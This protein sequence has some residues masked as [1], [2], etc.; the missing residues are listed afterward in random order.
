MKEFRRSLMIGGLTAALVMGCRGFA[1]AEASDAEKHHSTAMNAT[2]LK[3]VE[4]GEK[5]GYKVLFLGNSITLHG[6]APK[7]GWTNHCGMA[8]STVSNDY[9]HLVV[10]GLERV[11]RQKVEAHVLNIAEFERNFKDYDLA[12]GLANEIAFEPDLVVLAIGENVPA[13]TKKEDAAEYGKAFGRLIHL[14][15][16]DRK[17]PP[18][19]L[20][21]GVFWSNP[22]K[23]GQMKAAAARTGATFIKCDISG[24]EG[25]TAKG[26][27][28]HPGVQGHPG[29]NGMRE[30][31]RRI[32][33]ALR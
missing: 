18:T 22:V 9:V 15:Q 27:F 19:I 23:D 7:L 12:G 11:Y 3:P 16:H 29:D 2:P 24:E 13:L 8:A 33:N 31:A 26:L 5:G 21:R 20:V 1:F 14:F 32:L 30:I 10:R 28:E 4:L 25:M 6:I 17:R